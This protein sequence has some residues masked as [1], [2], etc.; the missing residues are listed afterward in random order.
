M[1]LIL[2]T[3]PLQELDLPGVIAFAQ[4]VGVSGLDLALRPGFPVNPDNA[5][6]ALPEAVARCRE[7]GLSL[8]LVS[9]PTDFA[10]P[11]HPQAA[12][13][14][15]ACAQAGVN[16]VKLGYFPYRGD[17]WAGFGQARQALASFARLAADQGVRFC[18]HT[19]SGPYYGSNGESL[20]QLLA[21][22]SPDQVGAYLDTGHQ[23]LGGAPWPMALD[24]V[25]SHLCALGLKDP[26]YHRREDGRWQREFVPIGQGLVDWGE[27]FRAA[28]EAGFA[29]PASIHA[30]YHYRSLQELESLLQREVA[31]L[32]SHLQG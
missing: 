23:R 9:L 27:V 19:H 10:D 30:E 28:R 11:S 29:G 4:R 24:A 14:A 7:A 17:Y 22:V 25:R 6:Q 20:A 32:R 15:A 31:Y 2:F 26:A 1:E 18:Y 16:L 13:V 21:E 5:A 12:A 8:P 3:K